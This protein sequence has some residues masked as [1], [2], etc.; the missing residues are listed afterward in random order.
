MTYDWTLTVTL[1]DLTLDEARSLQAQISDL[2]N[3]HCTATVDLEG[4][5]TPNISYGTAS[6]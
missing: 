3:L 6:A 2:A 5:N 1:A 4:E